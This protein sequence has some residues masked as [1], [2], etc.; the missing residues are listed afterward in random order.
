ML[1]GFQWYQVVRS[2]LVHERDILHQISHHGTSGTTC[3]DKMPVK[4][5]RPFGLIASDSQQSSQGWRGIWWSFAQ[6]PPANQQWSV[7]GWQAK[8]VVPPQSLP[9]NPFNKNKK[10]KNTFFSH[11]TFE[12]FKW[13][14]W[15]RMFFLRTPKAW[16]WPCPTKNT[17]TFYNITWALQ[18][19]LEDA[20]LTW[21]NLWRT[22]RRSAA[23]KNWRWPF[24]RFKFS[25]SAEKHVLR[26][27]IF[28][29]LSQ[30]E[31]FNFVIQI[32]RGVLEN[33][34]KYDDATKFQDLKPRPNSWQVNQV[35]TRL[36]SFKHGK[37][38]AWFQN[39]EMMREWMLPAAIFEWRLQPSQKTSTINKDGP[40]RSEHCSA[41]LPFLRGRSPLLWDGHCHS[42]VVALT[43]V[44]SSFSF[45]RSC[46]FN[47][48]FPFLSQDR[49]WAQHE[50]EYEY[51]IIWI[52]LPRPATTGS[53]RCRFQRSRTQKLT[54]P[55]QAFLK[56]SKSWSVVEDALHKLG[57]PDTETFLLQNLGKHHAP[58]SPV[59]SVV[60]NILNADLWQQCLR[61]RCSNVM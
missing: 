8:Q 14:P 47:H 56:L 17:K 21:A 7:Q 22:R 24:W 49:I 26:Y 46:R 37:R 54:K 4:H 58:T 42:V 39:I 11:I 16:A 18:V 51:E 15:S 13:K 3:A 60:L 23:L 27:W 43:D 6:L 36:L 2:N 45:L 34:R 50:Y 40:C 57:F 44:C 9:G 28:N 52:W 29:H 5:A 1:D 10:T 33:Q 38:D 53:I 35:V 30:Q 31:H 25:S 41:H 20:M 55:G 59:V 19:D 48:V 12:V 61:S 32:G